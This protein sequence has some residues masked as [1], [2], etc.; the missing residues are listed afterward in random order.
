MTDPVPLLDQ[1]FSRG[2]FILFLIGC[3]LF[4]AGNLSMF[5]HYMLTHM[6]GMADSYLWL[7]VSYLSVGVGVIL[8]ALAPLI[9]MFYMKRAQRQDHE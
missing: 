8:V 5:G 1:R 4:T 2:I 7:G 9:H 6:A 3:F